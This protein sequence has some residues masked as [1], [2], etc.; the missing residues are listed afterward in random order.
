M[1]FL[2][3]KCSSEVFDNA[4]SHIYKA[5][6][7]VPLRDDEKKILEHPKEIFLANLAV[8]MDDKTINI[9]P[10]IRVHYNDILGPTKGGIRYHPDVCEDEVKALAFWMTF[11]CAVADIPYGGAKGGVAV[12]PKKLSAHELEHLSRAYVEAMA[13]FIGP[14][15]DIPAPDVYTNATIMGW[16]MDEYNQITRKQNPAVIT[17]KPIHLGGSL[18]RETA[19]SLGGY[20]VF[21]EVAKKYNIKKGATVAIQGFGNVGKY[22][23]K[24]LHDAGYR[25]VA[26]SD[27]KGAA[28]DPN[29]LDIER[30][31]DYKKTE[32]EGAPTKKSVCDLSNSNKCI[33][34][35]ELLE[36]DVDVLIPAA[37]ENVITE[38]NAARIK[39]PV[40]LE[41]ANGPISSKASD[42]LTERK[43]HIV[44][45][46]LAN[47]GGVIV[48]YFEWVQNRSGLY[49]TED[50]VNTMLKEKITAAFFKIYAASV[51][52]KVSLR[53]A[54]YI[55]GLKRLKAAIESRSSERMKG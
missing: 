31:M 33:P 9:Y 5:Y 40:I 50:K 49:W 25:V 28:Y 51:E 29:G 3:D 54:A 53:T 27:S 4:L 32:E 43:I 19:T 21:L 47:A 1:V 39:A 22:M 52:H 55:V 12:D 11:K 48:S 6:P 38:K 30:M 44:P 37:L 17:G 35:S 24:Y 13:D 46:I 41:L 18:G 20:Y 26:V 15:K 7:F 10:A 16:M 36:L 34:N 14:D 42:M 8:P 23:A 2:K 45:D